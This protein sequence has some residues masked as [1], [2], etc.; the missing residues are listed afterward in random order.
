MAGDHARPSTAKSGQVL[1]RTLYDGTLLILP[2]RRHPTDS[3]KPTPAHPD[4][5]IRVDSS[6]KKADRFWSALLP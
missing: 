5:R 1:V 2:F 4:D 6:L 3:L